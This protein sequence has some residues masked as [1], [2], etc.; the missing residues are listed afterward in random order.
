MARKS[1]EKEPANKS[2]QQIETLR[3]KERERQAETRKEAS[4]IVIP[5][6]E[7]RQRRDS[8]EADDEE[9]LRWYFGAG[10]GLGDPFTFEFTENQRDMI[11]A[12]RHAIKHGDDQ[13]IADSR[14]GGKTTYTERCVLK[15]ILTGEVDYAVVFAATGH[16]AEDILD[17]IDT[18]IAENERLLADYPEVCLP[19]RELMGA[20]QRAN[21]QRATGQRH[22]N[23]EPY[24]MAEIA[25]RW[26][27]S[28]LIFPKV[29]GSPSAGA[30]IATRGLEGA[31]RGLKKRGKRPKLAVI[32]DPDTEDTARSEEQASKL[33]RR[34][35]AAIGGLGGQRRS[36][37]RVMLTT[38]QSRV[39]VS[40]KY[41]DPKQKQ[42]FKG[43][44]YRFMVKPPDAMNLVDEYMQ[45]RL[46]D[47]QRRDEH[48][49]DLDPF[50]RR[51]HAFWLA[52]REQIELSAIVA[53]PNR[54]EDAILPDG[55]QKEVSA[56]QHYYNLVAKLGADVVATEYDNDPPEECAVTDSGLAPSRIQRQL[57]GYDRRSIP[58]DCTT[59]TVG[60]D[61][62]KV[63]LHWTARAWRPDG[64]G[65]TVDYG[66]HEVVGTTYGSDVGVD[67]ALRTA[68]LHL[69]ESL[70]ESEWVTPDGELRPIDLILVDAGWKTD[71]VYSACHEVGLGILPVKGFGKSSG[72]VPGVFR[73]VQ[74]RTADKK[75]GDGWFLSRHGKLWLACVD[76]DRWKSYEHDRWLT[77]PDR[78][79]SMQLFGVPSEQP[80]GRMNDDEK[81]HHSYARHIC[82]ETEVEEVYKGTL[83]RRWKAKSENTHWLDASYYA[84]VAASIRGVTIVNAAP[85]KATEHTAA[86]TAAAR[87]TAQWQPPQ[88]PRTPQP[89]AKPASSGTATATKQRPAVQTGGWFSQ[90]TRRRA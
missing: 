25:Y 14:G 50:A 69:V 63:A 24:E 88:S 37:G 80:G 82:N 6:C 55:T 89:A 28:E 7:D 71:A 57:S 12:I 90:A 83:R 32:D 86:N 51:A 81:G 76:A 40:F 15:A 59:I 1:P 17:S 5:P 46:E 56:V 38:L 67:D 30:I 73:D 70:R 52:H 65:F 84:T 22:D 58:P 34:I 54:Y 23:G 66:V 62:R 77:P 44:R 74:R 20:P 78:T 43:R 26:C 31:V 18:Y 79:G 19:V 8:L 45:M 85:A 35:D 13:A 75:P 68:I 3:R 42:S 9:W 87:T 10:C 39:S 72:C 29:P 61:C 49:E 48:G 47:L 41:T 2:R 27:G 4:V 33:E 16:L 36:V 53:N 21:T 60:I 64:T 11:R